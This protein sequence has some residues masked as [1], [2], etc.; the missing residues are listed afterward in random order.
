[1]VACRSAGLMRRKL[2]LIIRSYGCAALAKPEGC[3]QFERAGKNDQSCS[4]STDY[5]YGQVDFLGLKM[6]QPMTPRSIPH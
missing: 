4:A 1:M 2:R 3:V 5:L 6:C